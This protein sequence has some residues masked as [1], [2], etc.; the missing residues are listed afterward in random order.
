MLGVPGVVVGEHFQDLGGSSLQA[1]RIC[2]RVRKEFGVRAA[3]EDL[4][5]SDTVGDFCTALA[6][7][8]DRA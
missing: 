8:T 2:A 7:A 1:I 6:R 5:E 4:F 3:P